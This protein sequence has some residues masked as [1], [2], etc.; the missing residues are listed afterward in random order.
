MWRKA[1]IPDT[2]SGD[3]ESSVA[4]QK[5]STTIKIATV[6]YEDS[7]FRYA[8]TARQRRVWTDYLT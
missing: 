8:A 5:L 6:S 4:D 3:W 7:V 1:A 2:D